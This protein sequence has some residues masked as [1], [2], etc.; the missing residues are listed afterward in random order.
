MTSNVVYTDRRYRILKECEI[1]VDMI[2][3][4]E[5]LT[6]EQVSDTK[7]YTTPSKYTPF[8]K[9]VKRMYRT[10]KIRKIVEGFASKYIDNKQA[11]NMGL[12]LYAYVCRAELRN[13]QY[14]LI[15]MWHTEHRTYDDWYPSYYRA[16]LYSVT[17]QKYIRM[18]YC[19][20]NWKRDGLMVRKD[21]L[22]QSYI[23]N[24]P[25]GE[26]NRNK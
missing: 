2:N 16:E 17:E 21:N 6:F 4:G 12:Q 20:N 24:N 13:Y 26:Y 25:G 19:G 7:L 18:W 1:T 9:G 8:T 22:S 3:N 10:E 15:R 11:M 5:I 14:K 23:D